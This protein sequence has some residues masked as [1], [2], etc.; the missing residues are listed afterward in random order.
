MTYPVYF[1]F[2]GLTP[3]ISAIIPYKEGEPFNSI[4]LCE[5][6]EAL[7]VTG[8]ESIGQARIAGTREA[9]NEWLVFMDA[10][11]VYPPNY[12]LQIK[13]WLRRSPS[14]MM[15]TIRR[16]GFG[17]FAW[18]VYEHSLVVQR[19]VFLKRVEGYTP[20]AEREDIGGLFQDAK[21]IPVEYFHG[22]TKGEKLATALLLSGSGSVLG[23]IGEIWHRT[24]S[25]SL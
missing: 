21:K 15:S 10:D 4:F 24:R 19:R 22:L 6:D 2:S 9:R 23:V 14:S 13:N 5:N 16:G 18:R 20:L 3:A 8:G 1:S 12:I 7:I 17:E 25:T 11:A